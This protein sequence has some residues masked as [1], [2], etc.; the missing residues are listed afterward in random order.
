L[1]KRVRSFFAADGG[2]GSVARINNG[3]LGKG[4]NLFMDATEKK[5][6]TSPRKIPTA[7]SVCKKDVTAKQ[8]IGFG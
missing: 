1:K 8:L 5:I 7:D 3:F 2:G 6:A 4:E